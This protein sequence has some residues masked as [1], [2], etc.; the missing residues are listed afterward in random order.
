MCVQIM[1][2]ISRQQRLNMT[3]LDG[4]KFDNSEEF[5]RRPTYTYVYV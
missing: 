5:C 4:V 2:V 1:A 3:R